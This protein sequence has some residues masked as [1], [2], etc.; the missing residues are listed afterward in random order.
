MEDV[1]ITVRTHDEQ[2][3]DIERL[4]A[5]LDLLGLVDVTEIR[6]LFEACVEYLRFHPPHR[7]FDVIGQMFFAQCYAHN[8][9]Q[10]KFCRGMQSTLLRTT[11]SWPGTL[12]EVFWELFAILVWLEAASEWRASLLL[13][14]AIALLHPIGLPAIK[15]P[16]L[17]RNVVRELLGSAG[18]TPAGWLITFP[19]GYR[20]IGI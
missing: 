11:A 15:V 14:A 5:E 20:N 6:E 7:F 19:L 9:S 18:F 13:S 1:W 17:K 16:A 8:Q 2:A 12:N 10:R 4:L 3:T